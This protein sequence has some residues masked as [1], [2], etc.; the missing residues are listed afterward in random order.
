[1]GALSPAERAQVKAAHDKA[2]QQDPSLEQKMKETRQAMESARKEMHAAMIKADPSVEPILAKMMPPR[3]VEKHQGSGPDANHVSQGGGGADKGKG[4]ANLT[5]SE[6]QQVMALREQVKQDPSV[7]AAHE[8]VKNATTPEAR[9]Q[10]HG[11]LRDAVHAAMIKADPS[12]EP[13]LEKMH[14]GGAAQSS[15][16]PVSQ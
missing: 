12:I 5:E 3:W 11:K 1:M 7:V 16:T 8:A 9:E 4:L 13:I 14:P 6:R 2:I 15:P 10:A